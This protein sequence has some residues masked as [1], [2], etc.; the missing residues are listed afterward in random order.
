M[1]ADTADLMGVDHIGIGSDLCQNQPDSVVEWMRVGRWSKEADYGEG[2][3]DN[4]GFPPQPSWF[5]DNTDF[6]NLIDGLTAAGFSSEDTAKVLG[7]NWLSFFERS[8]GRA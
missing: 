5:G 3:A 7:G 8:F 2:S 6:N 4:P 1:I